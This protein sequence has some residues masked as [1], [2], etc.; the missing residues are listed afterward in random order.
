MRAE[1]A[2]SLLHRP[3]VLFLDEPTIGLD[4]V[5]KSVIRDLLQRQSE[6]DGA[7]LL[8]TSHDTGDIERVCQ[9]VIVVHGGRMV[10]DGSI[11]ELR[12]GYLSTKR[13]RLHSE[14]EQLS[15]A[16]PGVRV[17]SAAPYQCELEVALDVTSLGAV[18]Q[19][20][21]AQ[22]GLRDVSIEDAPLDDVIRSLYAEQARRV[23]S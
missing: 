11:A 22:S 10:W 1:I 6:Q 21:L 5:A 13:L 23:A 15:L 12:R 4:V 3:R 18:L 9:R 7:T 14:R 17:L 20:A 2:A 16:L 8:F 19:A